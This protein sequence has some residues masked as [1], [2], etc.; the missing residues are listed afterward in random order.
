MGKKH[1]GKKPGY[2]KRSWI[3]DVPVWVCIYFI[4]IG[5]LIGY[6]F[7]NITW[8]ERALIDQS[9]A[10]PVTAIYN[11]H[12]FRYSSK[13][14]LSEVVIYFDDYEKLYIPGACVR[15]ETE[16]ALEELQGGEKLNLLLHPNS[17]DIWEVKSD[18]SAI[19]TFADAKARMQA[20][21]IGLSVIG[22][23]VGYLCAIMG[24]VSLLLQ[25]REYRKGK[26]C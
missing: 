20:D 17:G 21:N 23:I 8:H 10:I 16:D 7:T 1:K 5:I 24:A 19:L 14:P 26:Q 11:S 15:I 18:E 25:W 22:G 9:E 12:R 2:K 6:V 13:G 4:V 3:V